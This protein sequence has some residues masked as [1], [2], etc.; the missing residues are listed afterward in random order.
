MMGDYNSRPET[1][2]Y[3]LIKG[4]KPDSEILKKDPDV[5][6]LMNKDQSTKF[7]NQR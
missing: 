7:M 5:E 1:A 6:A 4:I 2:T 3:K